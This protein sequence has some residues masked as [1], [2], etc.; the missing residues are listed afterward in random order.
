MVQNNEYN[1]M[2][3]SHLQ[4]SVYKE[5]VSILFRYRLHVNRLP[6]PHHTVNN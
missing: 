4:S 3:T 1:L 5:V 6:E 2:K